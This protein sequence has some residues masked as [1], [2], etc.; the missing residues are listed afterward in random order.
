MNAGNRE[1]IIIL[2]IM[3]WMLLFALTA[4]GVFFWVWRKERGVASSSKRLE[5]GPPDGN[6]S[7]DK[8]GN[9]E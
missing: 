4:V 2:A 8:D 7:P 6:G 9:K 5:N 3:A 1:L